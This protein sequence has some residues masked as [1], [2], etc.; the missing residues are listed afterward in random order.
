MKLI[1]HYYENPKEKAKQLFDRFYFSKISTNK[2]RNEKAKI[3]AIICVD[4]MCDIAVQND[5]V[6]QMNY[7]VDV[8]KELESL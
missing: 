6:I 4:E 3:S 5:S 7:L 8:K 2:F 1:N